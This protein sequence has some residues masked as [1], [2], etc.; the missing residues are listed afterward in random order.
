LILFGF[1]LSEAFEDPAS[2]ILGLG[3]SDHIGGL[4]RV[5]KVQISQH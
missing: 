4:E 3:G 2:S 1:K 5:P